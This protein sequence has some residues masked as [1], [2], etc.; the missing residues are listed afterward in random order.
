M[1]GYLPDVI[2]KLWMSDDLHQS[3]TSASPPKFV[4][5][6]SLDPAGFQVLEPLQSLFVTDVMRAGIKILEKRRNQLRAIQQIKL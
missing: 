4:F 2:G 6:Q 3:R 1:R 5:G